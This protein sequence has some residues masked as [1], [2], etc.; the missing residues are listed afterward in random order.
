MDFK[1][2]RGFGAQ[3]GSLRSPRGSS[4]FFSVQ[5]QTYFFLCIIFFSVRTE[6]K[7]F[8][9]RVSRATRLAKLAGPARPARPARP[10]QLAKL[11]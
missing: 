1:K 6:E 11:A 9:S 7:C 10:A 8:I 4:I 3:R 5:S 2:S